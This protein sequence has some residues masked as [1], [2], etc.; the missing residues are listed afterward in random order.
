MVR[1]WRGPVGVVDCRLCVVVQLR[2]CDHFG[3]RLTSLWTVAVIIVRSP[4]RPPVP[5]GVRPDWTESFA[6]TTL[7]PRRYWPAAP[8]GSKPVAVA[9][10]PAMAPRF[11][12]LVVRR[13]RGNVRVDRRRGHRFRRRIGPRTL[14]GPIGARPENGGGMLLPVLWP[15]RG[16]C[17]RPARRERRRR[18]SALGEH[19]VLDRSAASGHHGCPT[20]RSSPRRVLSSVV[21][22]RNSA[23]PSVNGC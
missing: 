21:A 6:Q 7:P 12:P 10:T 23:A 3:T 9:G 18:E 15:W 1:E 8:P 2:G 22:A 4:W 13:V 20:V 17:H 16:R 11:V 19:E 14:R 5:P